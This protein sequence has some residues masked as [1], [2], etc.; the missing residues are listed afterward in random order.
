[1]CLLHVFTGRN[2]EPVHVSRNDGAVKVREERKNLISG[3]ETDNAQTLSLHTV[4]QV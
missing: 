1:M 4:D 2:D 3:P